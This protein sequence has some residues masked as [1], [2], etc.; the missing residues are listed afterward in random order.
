MLRIPVYEQQRC[1]TASVSKVY[2]QVLELDSAMSPI[3]KW[4][5]RHRLLAF[6]RMKG[7]RMERY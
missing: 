3:I 6:E 4:E 2:A 7:S 5:W 1:S